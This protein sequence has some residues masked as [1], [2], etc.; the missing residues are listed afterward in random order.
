MDEH[1]CELEM[2]LADTEQ[3]VSFEFGH[4]NETGYIQVMELRGQ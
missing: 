4:G 2:A 3:E 1:R